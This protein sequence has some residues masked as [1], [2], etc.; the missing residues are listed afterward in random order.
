MALFRLCVTAVAGVAVGQLLSIND[1]SWFGVLGQG[2]GALSHDDAIP[3]Q[4]Q[5]IDQRSFNVLYSASPLSDPD[6][7]A[8]FSPPGTTRE[9]LVG[10][11][12][13]IYDEEFLDIIGPNPTLTL[14]NHTE[15]DPIFH[16]APVW[17]PAKDEMF[18]V[19]NAGAKAAGTGLAKSA[20]IQK[21]SLSTVTPAIASQRN[22]SGSV[23]V[24]AVNSIPSVMNPNGATNYKGQLLFLGEGQG[25]TTAPAMYLMNP[26]PPYNTTVILDN[27]F[28]RQFNSLNDASIN[29]R[30]GEI[31]FTDPTY[32][33]VQ[34]FRP[35]PGMPKQVWRFNEATGAVAVAADGFNMPNG[36]AFSPNGAH[37]YV[38]DTGMA[39]AFYGSNFSF[40]STIYRYNVNEDGTLEN[41]KTFAFVTPGVPDGLHLD[42]KGNVYVGCGDGM[43]V[44]N[45]SGKLVGK[46]YTG[47]VSANFQFAGEGR[48]VVLAETELYFVTLAAE[49]AFPGRLY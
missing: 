11:P 9:S 13:H 1:L 40:P 12:F 46:I 33:Y 28:G 42:T 19:Q 44:Y 22:A 45:P 7:N 30:N 3:P 15:S 6:G 26:E 10:R 35:P 32:G 36:I 38:A 29:P 37:L 17:Y 5:V 4:A 24:E 2:V 23:K 8:Q 43:Q 21:I 31:Y 20:I 49:G 41:R 14:L 47:S 16:E 39:Q 27:F 25:E 48:M 34:D 18:F